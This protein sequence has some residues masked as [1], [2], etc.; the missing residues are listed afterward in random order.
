M[1]FRTPDDSKFADVHGLVAAFTG[2]GRDEWTPYRVHGPGNDTASVDEFYTFRRRGGIEEASVEIDGDAVRLTVH[3]GRHK[4]ID[5]DGD[6][7]LEIAAPF[8]REAPAPSP[9]PR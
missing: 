1:S 8:L 9:G 6:R 2:T 7:A 3:Q 4:V 5:I